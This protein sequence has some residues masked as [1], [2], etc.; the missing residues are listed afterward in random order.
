MEETSSNI[1]KLIEEKTNNVKEKFEKIFYDKLESSEIKL[2]ENLLEFN[3][4]LD[5][6]YKIMYLNSKYN[7]NELKRQAKD[8]ILK[9][10]KPLIENKIY[11]EMSK[12]LFDKF[13]LEFSKKVSEIFH[14]L[15]CNNKKIKEIF[16][17]K[18]KETGNICY[19]KI[20]GNL[21]YNKDDLEENKKIINKEDEED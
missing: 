3:T 21:K 9:D 15:L 2:A 10:L 12:I 14:D 6:K 13:A 11:K 4:N 5:S 8:N 16:K 19:N 1:D 17:E 7:F 18:G 20:K